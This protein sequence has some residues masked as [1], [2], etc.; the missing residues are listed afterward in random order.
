[1]EDSGH[2]EKQRSAETNTCTVKEIERMIESLG[3]QSPDEQGLGFAEKQLESGPSVPAV[4]DD[5]NESTKQTGGR[6]RGGMFHVSSE[7][8]FVEVSERASMAACGA[9]S[10][11]RLHYVQRRRS[12]VGKSCCLAS[13]FP[14]R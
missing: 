10:Q 7:Y 13:A 14:R 4:N 12:S 8:A 9:S 6:L 2:Q 5:K 1:M 3:V 11:E